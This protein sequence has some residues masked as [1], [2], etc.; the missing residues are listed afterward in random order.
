MKALSRILMFAAGI[1]VAALPAARAADDNPPAPGPAPTPAPAAPANDQPAGRPE[2]RGRMD[3]GQMLEHLKTAL[4]LTD[5]Q[6]AKV[7]AIVQAQGDKRRAIMEDDSLSREDRWAKVM[8]LMKST[9]DQIRA[10]LTP[11]QQQ[12]FDAMPR[13]GRGMRGEGPAGGPPP[14]PPADNA[15]PP[16]PA[17]N[18]PPPPPPGGSA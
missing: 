17:D 5:D 6:V 7:K 1:A 4:N 15:P 10:L 16:P 18:T 11:D 14:P 2:R 3:P 8:D 13:R 12:K 9:H